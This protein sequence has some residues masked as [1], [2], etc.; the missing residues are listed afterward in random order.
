M[1][2]RKQ[3]LY[4]LGAAIALLLGFVI[5]SAIEWKGNVTS[6]VVL[7]ARTD[8]VLGSMSAIGGLLSFALIFM[9]KN[10]PLQLKLTYAALILS[11]LAAIYIVY[12]VFLLKLS[13][14]LLSRSVHFGAFLPLI[15]GFMQ[16]MAARGV[17]ADEKLVKSAERLR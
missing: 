4:L 12:W 13:D 5:A 2:Q 14:P 9:Y 3:T 17:A 6:S 11:V 1:I 10:R 7:W 16:F 8:L 15:G